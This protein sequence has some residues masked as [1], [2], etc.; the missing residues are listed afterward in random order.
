MKWHHQ[1]PRVL[2]LVKGYAKVGQ[3]IL[4]FI[5]LPVLL[6]LCL[7]GVFCWAKTSISMLI[8]SVFCTIL[9]VVSFAGTQLKF[10]PKRYRSAEAQT[11][12]EM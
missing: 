3:G 1:R 9:V 7:S 6:I 11:D 5:Y 10:K 4:L 8:V 12:G 2:A